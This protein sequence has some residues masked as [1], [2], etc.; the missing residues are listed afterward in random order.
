[1]KFNSFV[2]HFLTHKPASYIPTDSGVLIRHN[3]AALEND[4][5]MSP[6]VTK[7]WHSL[8]PAILNHY[9]ERNAT[10]LR[11]I[12]AR[13]LDVSP[14]MITIGNGSDEFITHIADIFIEPD[15]SVI[16]QTP[17]FFRIIEAALKA[18]AKVIQVPA[19]KERA[20][21]LDRPLCVRLASEARRHRAGIIWLCTP[22]NPTGAVFTLND[23]AWLLGNTNALVV[24]DEAYLELFDPTQRQSAVR[25]LPTHKNLIVTKTLSKAFGLAGLRVGML[26]AHP[27]VIRIV[28]DWRLNFPVS[29]ISLSL[30]ASALQDTKHLIRIHREI[31]RERNRLFAA[32]ATLPQLEIGA[33]S[34]TNVFLLRHKTRNI[35]A[36]LLAQGIMTADFNRMNGLEGMHFVR[37]TVKRRSENNALITALVRCCQNH[38]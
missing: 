33:L 17:T 3:F 11:S 29:S 10:E 20:F 19:R 35:H 6:N 2:R 7:A 12:A 27:Q 34:K 30:A 36:L 16:V 18:K 1:M 38:S 5:G 28:D 13:W 21:A 24:V 37:I 15:Q 22:N 25:L 26:I 4:F 32:I 8:D 14:A 31:T 23:I 9:P